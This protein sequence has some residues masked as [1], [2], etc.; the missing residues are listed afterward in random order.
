MGRINRI[1][2]GACQGEWQCRVG[3]GLMHACLE[4]VVS[5]F[6][7]ETGREIMEQVGTEEFPVFDFAYHCSVCKEC[8]N[9]VSV[10]VLTLPDRNSE[11]IGRCPDCG[12]TAQPITDIESMPCPVC[13]E[14]AL[15][16]ET[17]GNW[18]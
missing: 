11:Y 7:K 5:E 17:A 15:L 18:D 6:P 10:P 8:N 12:G 1:A 3:C 13:G 14:K 2:C 9:I 4:D 16:E